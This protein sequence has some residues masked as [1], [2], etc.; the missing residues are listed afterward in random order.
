MRDNKVEREV[1]ALI[2]VL[3]LKPDK[4]RTIRTITKSLNK[5]IKSANN[6]NTLME[7]K[8]LFEL[9]TINH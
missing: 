9:R 6:K 7:I 1:N 8:A 3:N 5:R 4:K 2:I